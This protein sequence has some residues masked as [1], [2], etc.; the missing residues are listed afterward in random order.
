MK[1]KRIRLSLIAYV[2][3]MNLNAI[4]EPSNLTES[5][6]KIEV[7][8]GKILNNTNIK[9]DIECTEGGL[10]GCSLNINNS[11]LND[12]SIN[13][14]NINISNSWLVGK[15]NA[16]END[17]DIK[18]SD[19]KST[20]VIDAFS[21]SLSNGTLVEDG[22]TIKINPLN[23][24]E[25]VVNFKLDNFKLSEGVNLELSKNSNIQ[26]DN[27]SS[28]NKDLDI[29]KLTLNTNSTYTGTLNANSLYI[30]S[31]NIGENSKLTTNSLGLNTANIG[32]NTIINTNNLTLKNTTL[33]NSVKVDATGT[34]NIDSTSKIAGDISASSL[35]IANR[36]LE[37][38]KLSADKYILDGV[39]IKTDLNTKTSTKNGADLEI[40]NKVTIDSTNPITLENVSAA[41]NSRSSSLEIK[42]DVNITGNFALNGMSLKVTG[43]Q[44][45]KTNLVVEKKSSFQYNYKYDFENANVT[46]KSEATGNIRNSTISNSTING[47]TSDISL[48]VAGAMSTISNST[49]DL[50]R[51]YIV[52]N[53][54]DSVINLNMKRN[55][56]EEG[57]SYSDGSFAGNF[58]NTK[59][60]SSVSSYFLFDGGLV[61]AKSSIDNKDGAVYFGLLKYFPT[62]P[63]GVSGYKNIELNADILSNLKELKNVISMSGRGQFVSSIDTV[64]IGLKTKE[65]VIIDDVV[66][67]DATITNEAYLNTNKSNINNLVLD[68]TLIANSIEANDIKGTGLIQTNSNLLANLNKL[69]G[70]KLDVRNAKITDSTLDTSIIDKIDETSSNI[71]F[72]GKLTTKNDLN[73]NLYTFKNDVEVIGAKFSATQDTGFKNVKAKDLEIDYFAKTNLNGSLEANTMKLNNIFANN[74]IIKAENELIANNSEFNTI[75]FGA[76]ANLI[77]NDS[78]YNESIKLNTFDKTNKNNTF[79]KDFSVGSSTI[80]ADNNTFLGNVSSDSGDFISTKHSGYL[81]ISANNIDLNY[82]NKTNLLGT[83]TAKNNLSVNNTNTNYEI[84]VGN[85]LTANKSVFNTTIDAKG[86]LTSTNSIYNGITKVG[87]F[88]NNSKG[89]VFNKEIHSA[90]NIYADDNTFNDLVKAGGTLYASKNNHFKDID[91][92][93]INFTGDGLIELDNHN[94]KVDGDAY[95]DGMQ[96]NAYNFLMNNA[97]I[98]NTDTMAY[99]LGNKETPIFNPA[100]IYKPNVISGDYHID[101]ISNKGGV[102]ANSFTSNNSH[103]VGQFVA[104]NLNSINTNYY[105]LGGGIETT[106]YESFSGA[107]IARNS[108]AGSNNSIR[109]K[110]TNILGLT[111]GLVPVAIIKTPSVQRADASGLNKDYFK[112]SYVRGT[113]LYSFNSNMEHYKTY[114]TDD[115]SVYHAWLVGSTINGDEMGELTKD[116]VKGVA[117]GTDDSFNAAII[118]NG[119]ANKGTSPKD[120]SANLVY[121]DIKNTTPSDVVLKYDDE[122]GIIFA[123]LDEEQG[124]AIDKIVHNDEHIAKIIQEANKQRLAG[125]RN[126]NHGLGFWYYAYNGR[127]Y[128]NNGV[129][130]YKGLNFGI[131]KK[132]E[133]KTNDLYIG[134]LANTLQANVSKSIEAVVDVKTAGIYSTA[135]F[136]NGLFLDFMLAYSGIKNDISE[137][138]FKAID[139]SSYMMLANTSIGY[140]YGKN[141]YVEPSFSLNASYL[142][143]YTMSRDITQVRKKSKTLLSMQ[144]SIAMGY[145]DDKIDVF[146]QVGFEKDISTSPYYEIEDDYVIVQKHGTKDFRFKTTFGLGYNPR[147]NTNIQLDYSKDFSG[148]F[149]N[150]YKI[151]LGVRHSF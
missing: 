82:A 64:K 6:N 102:R 39:V 129:L 28:L 24:Y 76:N 149:I 59:I 111:K 77:S 124:N 31:A 138:A 71:T 33:D 139:S 15:I 122:A 106:L 100:E 136:H 56:F 18:N 127:A 40:K 74:Q 46:F 91:V 1:R 68:G 25:N 21:L 2:L 62:A 128:A 145:N 135:M 120:T 14:T 114:T 29:N 54:N 13:A 11:I 95:I 72:N 146:A 96:V 131:D 133:N 37:N 65:G 140:K 19:I 142:P 137:N 117:D 78:I 32:N 45:K 99:L 69:D 112:L 70:L 121:N 55:S 150:D 35:E 5:T 22:S 115:G 101:S 51:A 80:Y 42:S 8:N 4:E 84:N 87:D 144:P 116:N 57:Y 36:T 79:K 113:N 47:K 66:L 90:K 103:L 109:I 125:L 141:V 50:G 92:T 73:A 83:L 98:K 132:L 43:T 12:T 49:L 38:I 61:D 88:S 17:I 147:A 63:A 93:N 23:S 41:K 3:V 26:L 7:E 52:S 119:N 86:L 108:G 97:I 9:H 10:F 53:V 27:N 143:S 67:K 126:L 134:V 75:L 105:L 48:G 34:I 118:A 107:I 58:V 94:L 85:N 44:D 123:G 148:N 30:Y 81:N 104:N 16:N 110:D 89:N 130:K 20:A 151:N 60:N